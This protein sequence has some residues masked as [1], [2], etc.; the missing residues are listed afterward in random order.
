MK[1]ISKL[2]TGC[3]L[4]C[5]L[6]VVA[7]PNQAD[8]KWLD[9]VQKMVAKGETKVST[10]SEERAKLLKDWASKKGYSAEVTKTEA[11]FRVVLTKT[12]AQN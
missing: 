6:T 1:K 10:H 7:E 11:G 3:F 12:L 8:Q 2:L 4:A 5:A 9:A